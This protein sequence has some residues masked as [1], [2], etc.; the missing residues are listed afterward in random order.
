MNKILYIPVK[1]KEIRDIKI[2]IFDQEEMRY[3]YLMI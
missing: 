1:S 3:T 2:T